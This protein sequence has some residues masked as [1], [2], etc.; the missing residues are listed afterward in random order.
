MK[1]HHLKSWASA[2]WGPAPPLWRSWVDL[3]LCGSNRWRDTVRSSSSTHF[4]SR[5]WEIEIML[6]AT[7]GWHFIFRRAFPL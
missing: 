5:E 1:E 7:W 4:T 3:D 6:T 2:K